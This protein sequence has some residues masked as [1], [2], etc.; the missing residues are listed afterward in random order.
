MKARFSAPVQTD[1]GAH[2]ASYTMGTGFFQEVKRPERGVEHPPL[3]S[4]EVK[5]RVELYIYSPSGPSGPVLGRI[6]LICLFQVHLRK[7]SIAHTY[8]SS[9]WTISEQ[10]TEKQ[11]RSYVFLAVGAPDRNHEL[12]KMLQL[13]T[14]FFLICIIN[15]LNPELNPIC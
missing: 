5:E 14:E 1:P 7:L 15:P 9:D 2:P 13:F 11:W 3:S 6:S 12:R 10:C 8:A 4:A